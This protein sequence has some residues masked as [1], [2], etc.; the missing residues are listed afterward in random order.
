[1][2]RLIIIIYVSTNE[3]FRW[4]KALMIAPQNKELAQIPDFEKSMLFLK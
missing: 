1:M 2:E 3:L 4:N